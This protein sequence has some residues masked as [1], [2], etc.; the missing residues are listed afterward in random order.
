MFQNRFCELSDNVKQVINLVV[1]FF[2]VYSG[3]TLERITHEEAPWKDARTNC[4]P[5][6]PS[7][8]VIPKEAI[9]VYF[10]EVAKKYDLSNVN[11]IRSYINSGLQ[12]V[13]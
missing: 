8:V 12:I 13:L 4:L 9:K 11:G 5:D 3:K 6:E 7:N 1:D 10:S 2:G